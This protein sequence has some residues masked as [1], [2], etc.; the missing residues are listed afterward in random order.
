MQFETEERQFATAVDNQAKLVANLVKKEQ[1]WK[2]K[3][4]ALEVQKKEV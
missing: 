2:E 4:A 3:I 1:E